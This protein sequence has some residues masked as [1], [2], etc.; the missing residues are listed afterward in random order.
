M[1]INDVSKLSDFKKIISNKKFN[2][3]FLITGKIHTLN[4]K[5]I[6]FLIFL[7]IN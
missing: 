2:K 4:Q 1:I 3:I 7:K 5:Q 6:N